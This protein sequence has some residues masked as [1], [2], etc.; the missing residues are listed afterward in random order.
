MVSH[1]HSS[2]LSPFRCDAFD[3]ETKIRQSSLAFEKANLAFNLASLC[4]KIATAMVPGEATFASMAQY[5]QA[6][7]SVFSWMSETFLHPPLVDLQAA[8]LRF[9]SCLM[10]AQAQEC[11]LLKASG[12]GKSAGTLSRL[13]AALT[14]RYERCAGL[15]QCPEGQSLAASLSHGCRVMT[16]GKAL[17]YGALAAQWRAD[18]C[19]D[20]DGHGEAVARQLHA[21][22]LLERLSE[23][24]AE[25]GVFGDVDALVE[26]ASK[27]HEQLEHE[28]G[29][30]Y[31]LAVPEVKSLKPIEAADLTRCLGFRDVLRELGIDRYGVDGETDLFRRVLPQRA[32]EDLSLYSEETAKL[33]RYETGKVE[34]ADE[35]LEILQIRLCSLE[36]DS[37]G[38]ESSPVKQ[39][40]A[41]IAALPPL[42]DS[43]Q[44]A[45]SQ[46]SQIKVALEHCKLLKIEDERMQMAMRSKYGAT[47][48]QPPLAQ[49]EDFQSRVD[50]T[51]SEIQELIDKHDRQVAQSLHR[52]IDRIARLDCKPSSA[53]LDAQEEEPSS[54]EIKKSVDALNRLAV[55]RAALLSKLK[56]AISDDDI[57]D[58]LL[59]PQQSKS[60]ELFEAELRKFDGLCDEIEGN[61]SEHTKLKKTIEEHFADEER[62]DIRNRASLGLDEIERGM[63]TI[64]GAASQIA[65]SIEYRESCL[66]FHSIY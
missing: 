38:T 20:G 17:Y 57:S 42:E 66:H 54:H 60:T 44:T 41:Q 65:K 52:L 27:R 49:S 35:E 55:T 48:S 29:F 50:K 1:K 3:S 32:L 28:N 63:A 13:S 53:L 40:Q 16:E 2:Y 46:L 39:I 43:L 56:D 4:S 30:I 18:T 45:K 51:A 14:L 58:R 59:H 6:A 62:K 23:L 15:L 19:A 25:S 47:W 36:N 8:S 7:G 24:D 11:V 22:H 10:L 61:V 5:Y 31:H 64:Q 37:D 12:E 34:A 21:I 26:I 33:L 9:L